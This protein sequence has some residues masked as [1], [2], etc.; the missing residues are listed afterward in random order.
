MMFVTCN[1]GIRF[2]WSYLPWSPIYLGL[3]LGDKPRSEDIQGLYNEGGE[4]AGHG[5]TNKVGDRQVA[6]GVGW[7]EIVAWLLR[8]QLK[9]TKLQ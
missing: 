2:V 6:R 9:Q 5:P 7:R 3:S 8:D 4:T 1:Y